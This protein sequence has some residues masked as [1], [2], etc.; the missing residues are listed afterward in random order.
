LVLLVISP[1]SLN[2]NRG[3]GEM[4]ETAYCFILCS[5]PAPPEK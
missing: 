2:A 3:F 4:L 5:T 1:N